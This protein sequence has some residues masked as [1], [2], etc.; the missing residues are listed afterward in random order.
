MRTWK[1]LD[2]YGMSIF[3]QYKWVL[4]EPGQVGEWVDADGPVELCRHGIHA[5]RADDLIWWIH[6]QLWEIEL[7]GDIEEGEYLVAAPRARLVRSVTGWPDVGPELA[8]FAISRSRDRAVEFLDRQGLERWSTLLLE[9]GTHG[10]LAERAS[11]VLRQPEIDSE[12]RR[13]VEWLVD[14]VN[15][16]PNVVIAAHSSAMGEADAVTSDRTDPRYFEA[17]AAA[18]REQSRWL[19]ERLGL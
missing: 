13:R 14:N 2:E 3:S 1:F 9:A 7:D 11:L 19:V 17:F 8:D 5:C 4:P 18:R 16:L 10:E 12:T 15:D 6:T